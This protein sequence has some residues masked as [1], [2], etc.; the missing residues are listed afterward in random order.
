MDTRFAQRCV[1]Q[2]GDCFCLFRAATVPA[3]RV[4]APL[5]SPRRARRTRL[6][7]SCACT[8]S[9]FSSSS[10]D[11]SGTYFGLSLSP[12]AFR[13]SHERASSSDRR[14]RPAHHLARFAGSSV[15][16]PAISLIHADQYSVGNGRAQQGGKGREA[17]S[18]AGGTE[19]EDGS[20][21]GWRQAVVQSAT[22]SIHTCSRTSYV[23]MGEYSNISFPL[24]NR[25][26]H[27]SFL[28]VTFSV[29]IRSP[30]AIIELP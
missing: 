30:I 13:N 20:C 9:N 18:G 1:S 10:I 27:V 3:S 25:P 19:G 28:P 26:L 7:A 4:A 24:V 14:D 6:P 11:L 12:S 29:H 16:R 21:Q 8:S 23:N 15:F 2:C 5:A 17:G 22:E